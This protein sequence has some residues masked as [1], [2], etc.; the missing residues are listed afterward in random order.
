M[1]ITMSNGYRLY[2]ITLRMNYIAILGRLYHTRANT[3]ERNNC[4]L[5]TLKLFYDE[6][7]FF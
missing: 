6:L 7:Y 1:K 4:Y 3:K 5:Y 2:Y